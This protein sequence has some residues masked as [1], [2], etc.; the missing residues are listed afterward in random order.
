MD[1]HLFVG[2][3]VCG[4]LWCEHVYLLLYCAQAVA[5]E[6]LSQDPLTRWGGVDSGDPPECGGKG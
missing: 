4:A 3:R 6:M 1:L 5:S 2:R